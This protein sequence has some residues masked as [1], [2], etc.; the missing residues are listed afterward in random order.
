MVLSYYIELV[1]V[2]SICLIVE[3]QWLNPYEPQWVQDY[4]ECPIGQPYPCW[5]PPYYP[6]DPIERNIEHTGKVVGRSMIYGEGRY[7]NMFIGI[8]YAKPPLHELR[9]KVS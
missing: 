2:I 9:F 1:V 5:R 4:D 6:F 8:P 3:C 7:V